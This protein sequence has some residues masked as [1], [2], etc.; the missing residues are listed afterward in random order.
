MFSTSFEK[1][2][3]KPV[4]ASRSAAEAELR[5]W[6]RE[7]HYHTIQDKAGLQ[8]QVLILVKEG[9][10]PEHNGPFWE[11]S[12]RSHTVLTAELLIQTGSLDPI[13]DKRL[14]GF[15]AGAKIPLSS[16]EKK[17]NGDKLEGVRM[18]L[19]D[20]IRKL[21]A[22]IESKTFHDVKRKACG[23][24]LDREMEFTHKHV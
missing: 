3:S 11:L 18:A 5:Y 6:L 20:Y 24:W 21:R 1:Y 10:S 22:F 17:L 14:L 23:Q 19:A 15:L 7:N 9:P 12:I 8:W 13:Q 4:I 2:P 16:S